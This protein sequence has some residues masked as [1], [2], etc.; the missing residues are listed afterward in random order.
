MILYR[1]LAASHATIAISNQ[2]QAVRFN[3]KVF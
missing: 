2:N 3:M 1:L